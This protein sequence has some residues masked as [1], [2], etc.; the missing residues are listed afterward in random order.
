MKM[1]QYTVKYKSCH[2]VFCLRFLLTQNAKIQKFDLNTLY[3]RICS[4]FRLLEESEKE[5]MSNECW[6]FVIDLTQMNA[7]NEPAIYFESRRLFDHKVMSQ[8]E[9]ESEFESNQLY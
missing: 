9:Y 1:K 2:S 7:R 8:Q 3:E 6:I 4:A 5:I